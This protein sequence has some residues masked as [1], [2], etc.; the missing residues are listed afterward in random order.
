M[1]GFGQR[2][3]LSTVA[4]WMLI[5]VDA[6]LPRTQARENPARD[7][8]P[9]LAAARQ[10]LGGDG[11]LSAIKSFSATGRTRQVR[12]ENLVPIEFEI[13]VELPD[14]YLR[15]D[16]IPAQET[17]P[18]A[19]GFNGDE[20]LQ[21]PPAASAAAA[22]AGPPPGAAAPAPASSPRDAAGPAGMRG[23]AAAAS[24]GRGVPPRNP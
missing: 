19:S 24:S 8:A 11:R 17:G 9:I 5:A 21:D 15:K 18:S 1:C 14:K 12:G 23:A 4:A 16:E 6:T 20:L 13:F 2:A 3:V 22:A 7:P 10:A